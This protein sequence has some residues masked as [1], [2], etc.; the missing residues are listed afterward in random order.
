MA[1]GTGPTRMADTEAWQDLARHDQGAARADVRAEGG[2]SDYPHTHT[3]NSPSERMIEATGEDVA[4][5]ED[6][7]DD[8]RAT[9]YGEHAAEAERWLEVAR[10]DHAAAIAGVDYRDLADH[11]G[12]ESVATADRVAAYWPCG[13]PET[14]AA[15]L[16]EAEQETSMEAGQ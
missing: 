2:G 12:P 15:G 1:A 16:A 9:G 13:Y 3:G 10:E 8:Y 6:I 11:F 4:A 7:R 5:L 14:Q